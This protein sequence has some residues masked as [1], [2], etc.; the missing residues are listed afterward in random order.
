MRCLSCDTNLSDK[1]SCLKSPVTGEYYDLCFSCL[2]DIGYIYEDMEDEEVENE[3][4]EL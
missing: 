3:M 4:S 2:E 1:E